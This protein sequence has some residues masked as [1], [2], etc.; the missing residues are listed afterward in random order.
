VPTSRTYA[1]FFLGCFAAAGCREPD[2]G[3]LRADLATSADA[4]CAAPPARPAHGPKTRDVPPAEIER[5]LVKLCELEAGQLEAAPEPLAVLHEALVQ[6]RAITGNLRRSRMMI[7]AARMDLAAAPRN[8]GVRSAEETLAK[9]VAGGRC[10]ATWPGLDRFLLASAAVESKRA[11]H[12]EALALCADVI[13]LARDEDLTGGLT[14]VLLAN[15]RIQ[16]TVELCT[17]FVDAAPKEAAAKLAASLTTLRATFP[18]A[19][20]DV[21]ARDRAEMMLFSFGKGR[22]PSRPFACERANA[23]AAASDGKPLSRADRVELERSWREARSQNVIPD[24]TYNEAYA[25]TLRV[26]EKLI[27]HAKSR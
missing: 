10:D 21:I 11:H 19:L 13:A 23:I 17:P 22:D 12:A 9:R 15:S 27:E 8:E 3:P 24:A 26:L 25:L 6:E 5:A 20:D 1:L 4:V 2:L 7:E 16:R 18:A 14:D